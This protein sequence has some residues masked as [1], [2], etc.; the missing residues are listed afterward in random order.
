L[1][2][3]TDSC[4][5]LEDKNR[6]LQLSAGRKTAQAED[7]VYGTS[8]PDRGG[9][10]YPNPE[11]AQG[12]KDAAKEANQTQRDTQKEQQINHHIIILRDQYTTGRAQPVLV[13]R[14]VV[15]PPTPGSLRQ[16]LAG[17]LPADWR[18]SVAQVGGLLTIT[19]RRKTGFY[20]SI[21]LLH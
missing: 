1:K 13:R 15:A 4:L 2:A 5:K 19:A 14:G 17:A 6:R 12:S 8:R 9:G 21:S 7:D 16:L 10:S 18:F 3:I 20:H 11:P